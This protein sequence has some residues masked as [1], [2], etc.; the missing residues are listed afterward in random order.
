METLFRIASNLGVCDSNRYCTSRRDRAMQANKSMA[1]LDLVIVPCIDE[2]LRVGAVLLIS[3]LF[4]HSMNREGKILTK[5][6]SL[7]FCV[8]IPLS[9]EPSRS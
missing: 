1:D 5:S 8:K 7:I 3:T 4:L 6:I 9:F 2:R